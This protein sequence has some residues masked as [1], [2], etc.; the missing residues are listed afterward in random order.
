MERERERAVVHVLYPPG[1]VSL[2]PYMYMYMYLLDHQTLASSLQHEDMTMSMYEYF[3]ESGSN[4]VILTLCIHNEAVICT[5][6][7]R[8]EYCTRESQDWPNWGGMV[9]QGGG[10]IGPKK[11]GT[12]F[13]KTI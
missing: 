12:Y 8:P 11:G 3:P 5:L 9:L 1:S 2:S 10:G 6:A 13:P 4:I 7:R